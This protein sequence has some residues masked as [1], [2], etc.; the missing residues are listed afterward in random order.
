MSKLIDKK[1]PGEMVVFSIAAVIIW[2]FVLSYIFS[3]LWAVMA[4]MKTSD[5]ITMAPFAIPKTW[6]FENFIDSLTLLSL[7]SG[8]N[9]LGMIWNSLVLVIFGTIIAM[10]GNV[11]M[12]Y[13]LTKYDF[14]GKKAI[15]IV[16][17]IVMTLP[18]IGT[19]GAQYRLFSTLGF[20][21]SPTIL[22]AFISGYGA[23]VLLLQ[24]CFAGLPKEYMD[25]A[26]ID[27]AGNF[28]TMLQIM[29]PLAS[30]TIAALSVRVA[31]KYWNDTGFVLLFMPNMPTLA[32]GIYLFKE[33]ASHEARKD[34][35]MAATV[36]SAIPPI[37]LYAVANKTMLSNLT[38][39]G[40]KG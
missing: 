33:V 17:L 23:N 35:L 13:A 26:F 6:H 40:L 31:V 7:D 12:A 2:T 16:N 19:S 25:A 32:T 1:T 21:D 39:G 4:S 10:A 36:I 3:L 14:F 8:V 37:V 29:L 38:I 27:G 11:L 22:F 30:G 24:A 15:I 28:R 5:E 20:I 18:V 34:I 9:M